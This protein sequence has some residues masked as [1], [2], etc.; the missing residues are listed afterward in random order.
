MKKFFAWLRRT[1]RSIL[2]KPVNVPELPDAVYPPLDDAPE[3]P[4][5]VNV[6]DQDAGVGPD[7]SWG[8]ESGDEDDVLDDDG[9]PR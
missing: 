8:T 1:F 2:N 9:N 7:G 3:L 4:D 5:C 6:P